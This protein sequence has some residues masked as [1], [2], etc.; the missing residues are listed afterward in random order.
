MILPKHA[1]IKHL[2]TGEPLVVIRPKDAGLALKLTKMALESQDSEAFQAI[3]QA[4]TYTVM[5]FLSDKPAGFIVDE[6]GK[7]LE[8]LKAGD[9]FTTSESMI[10]VN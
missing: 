3:L 5:G 7:V 8:K 9:S 4:Q 1:T 10:K 6:T 2:P